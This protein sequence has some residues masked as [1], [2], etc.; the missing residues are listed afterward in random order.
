[1]KS[2]R[3]GLRRRLRSQ[4]RAAGSRWEFSRP[5]VAAAGAA[6]PMMAGVRGPDSAAK[7]FGIRREY[8][9]QNWHRN[10]VSGP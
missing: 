4:S 2:D 8:P 5:S 7:N 9:I 10:L 3:D 1:M 6:R